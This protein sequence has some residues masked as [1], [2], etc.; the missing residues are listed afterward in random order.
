MASAMCFWT[1]ATGSPRL[2]G[3]RWPTSPGEVRSQ[4]LAVITPPGP[5]PVTSVRSTPFCRAMNRT[6]G[7]PGAGQTVPAGGARDML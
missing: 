2:A 6:G 5:W 1:P 3:R 4:V 7:A